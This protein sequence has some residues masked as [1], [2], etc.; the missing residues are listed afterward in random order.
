MSDPVIAFHHSRENA[1]RF[2][3]DDD[4]DCL[5][6]VARLRF[7]GSNEFDQIADQLADAQVLTGSWGMP[8]LDTELL[9]AAPQ[10][11]AVCYAAGSVKGFVTPEAFERGI[12]V[13]TAMHANAVPVAEITLAL[14]LLANKNWFACQDR[15]HRIS[16]GA[17]PRRTWRSL[18]EDDHQGNYGTSV[19][20][21]GLGAIGR[22][23]LERLR[24]TDLT[25]F[26]YDPHLGDDAITQLGAEPVAELEQLA[27]RSQVLSLHAPNIPATEGMID[28]RILAAMPDGATFIN[29][30]RGKLVDEA[31]LIAELETGRICAMLDVTHPEPPE[32]DSPLLSL[33]N[34]WLTPHR[35]GSSAGEVRR[36][37]RYATEEILRFLAGEPPRHPV[38]A[39]ML[40]TMA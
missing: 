29:T 7:L 18:R 3:T 13:T 22:L 8:K 32:P 15:I 34:C 33:P 26:A 20:L 37:G 28:A 24:T 25:V 21:V 1:G 35:A 4:L 2:F 6:Q 14:I 36:M 10:L 5:S 19:G 30:A 9:A 27:A 40:E 17:D 31:A 11:A 23:V 39:D 38:T 12:R 16:E